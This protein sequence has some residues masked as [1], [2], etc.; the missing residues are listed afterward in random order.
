MSKPTVQVKHS[1]VNRQEPVKRARAIPDKCRLCSKL[2]AQQAKQ[3]HGSAPEGDGCWNSAVCPSRRSHARHHDRRNHARNLKRWQE[4][5]GITIPLGESEITP[6]QG[7][8]TVSAVIPQQLQ[9]D[10]QLSDVV[11]S[12][13][14]QVYRQSVD[15][16]LHAVGGEIWL[17]LHKLADITPI[18]CL[19]L[20]PRQVE[21]YLERLLKKLHEV[22]GIRKF[23]SKEELH[24]TLCRLS[25]Y[26]GK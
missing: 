21:V 3:I 7:Q 8:A 17:G 9:F 25:E 2:P 18:H 20:T 23:A 11:Y 5:G 22:Y 13:V 19:K 12:A 6:H 1:K 24:P 16:P 14:L 15:A 10:A 4:Q 26:S